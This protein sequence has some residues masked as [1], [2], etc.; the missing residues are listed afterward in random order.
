MVETSIYAVQ[1]HFPSSRNTY[2][3][4]KE[5]KINFVKLLIKLIY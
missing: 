4:L 5:V 1:T 2:V 3:S